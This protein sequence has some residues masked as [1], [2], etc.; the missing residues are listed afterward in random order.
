M[1]D[2]RPIEISESDFRSFIYNNTPEQNRKLVLGL[3]DRDDHETLGPIFRHTWKESQSH[4]LSGFEYACLKGRV[5]CIDQLIT[6]SR[7]LLRTDL[8]F[9]R[10]ILKICTPEVLRFLLCSQFIHV[11]HEWIPRKRIRRIVVWDVTKTV[12]EIEDHVARLEKFH[13]LADFDNSKY[14]EA[15]LGCGRQALH[16]A[17]QEQDLELVKLLVSKLD[18][19][20]PVHYS[21]YFFGRTPLDYADNE[22]DEGKAIGDYLRSLGAMTFDQLYPLAPL[23]I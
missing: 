9:I 4:A 2:M 23:D 21:W 17:A 13:I 7:E 1:I 3:V 16:I 18:N 19:I 12:L 11:S 6:H 5:D 8:S 20:N 10:T 14:L 22:T 15:D